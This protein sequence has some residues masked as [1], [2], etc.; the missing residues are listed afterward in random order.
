MAQATSLNK[1]QYNDQLK[2][3]N[4]ANQ[5]KEAEKTVEAY[6]ARVAGRTQV[7]SRLAALHLELMNVEGSDYIAS[8]L[9]NV[10]DDN[11]YSRRDLKS[12]E[13]S[14]ARLKGDEPTEAGEDF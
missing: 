14:L 3:A 13:A 4:K 7:A 6:K 5:L 10:Q 12:A 1:T 8:A 2:A 11:T 9:R